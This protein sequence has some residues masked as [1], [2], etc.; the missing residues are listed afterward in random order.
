MKANCAGSD[1]D[2]S[3]PSVW[4]DNVHCRINCGVSSG[5]LEDVVG[6]I[7]VGTENCRGIVVKWVDCQVGANLFCLGAAHLAR[8]NHGNIARAAVSQKHRGQQPDGTR[9][10]HDSPLSNAKSGPAYAA[11]RN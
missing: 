9:A 1:T 7:N 8:L 3:Y 10:N 11:K 5:A 6:H 2:E 4:S